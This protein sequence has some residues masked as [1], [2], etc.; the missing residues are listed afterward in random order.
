[1]I[2]L[3]TNERVHIHMFL[4]LHMQARI[5]DYPQGWEGYISMKE[6]F[7]VAHNFDST[8]CENRKR[9]RKMLWVKPQP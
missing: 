4:L 1:M 3:R 9:K 8:P 6:T 7:F 5:K 2:V